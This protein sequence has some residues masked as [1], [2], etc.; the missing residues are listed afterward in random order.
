MKEIGPDQTVDRINHKTLATI[1]QIQLSFSFHSFSIFF[2]LYLHLFTRIG[3]RKEKEVDTKTQ[4]N[5]T[6]SYAKKQKWYASQ[7]H[8]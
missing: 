1:F 6:V 4:L 2:R 8:A 3:L 7:N 5:N